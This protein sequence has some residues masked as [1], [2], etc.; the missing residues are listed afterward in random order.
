LPQWGAIA[1]SLLIGILLGRAIFSR[2]AGAIVV[3]EGRM[4]AGAELNAALNVQ[5]SGAI[6]RETGIQIGV[7]YLAKSGEYCRTFTLRDVR[8]LTGL[9]CRRRGEWLIDAVTPTKPDA[10]GAY[11]MAGA[12]VPALIL[13]L[14]EDT[15]AGD[16]L[17]A[18]QESDARDRAWQR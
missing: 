16:P 4:T 12:F 1:V 14:A 17:D 10:S 7:S 2:E 18:Q 11:R 5:S 9:S 8:A 6:D 13:G 3:S 15:M